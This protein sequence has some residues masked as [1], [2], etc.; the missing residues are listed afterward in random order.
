V[1]LLVHRIVAVCR[2]NH[3][4]LFSCSLYTDISAQLWNRQQHKPTVNCSKLAVSPVSLCEDSKLSSQQIPMAYARRRRLPILNL[5]ALED[6][7]NHIG[8]WPPR[9]EDI[10]VRKTFIDFGSF[11][12]LVGTPP[13]SPLQPLNTA[14]ARLGCTMQGAF[15]SWKVVA[16]SSSS[17]SSTLFTEHTPTISGD[18]SA[19]SSLWL[20]QGA[21]ELPDSIAA[22]T[23]TSSHDEFGSQKAFSHRQAGL[24]PACH[25]SQLPERRRPISL[26]D[27]IGKPDM[28]ESSDAGGSS[29]EEFEG[30][31]PV[32]SEGAP[33]PSLG[34]A[35]HGSG[36]CKRCCF[37]PKGRCSNG[38]DCEFCHFSHDK[39]KNVKSKK[40]KSRRRKNRRSDS[41]ITPQ[42]TKA[43]SMEQIL[44]ISGSV[45]AASLR[46]RPSQLIVHDLEF[47]TSTGTTAVHPNAMPVFPKWQ[48]F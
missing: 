13:E 39:R 17:T 15:D 7:S 2:I 3:L 41:Q 43:P 21:G 32:F 28:Q 25:S 46:H 5:D 8:Q 20:E 37:F 29:D 34:S 42:A 33:L 31:C 30:L 12:R 40:K 35:E 11:A 48:S 19:R 4:P 14:P 27:E 9:S 24:L 45:C 36:K 44:G 16:T 18:S 26:A 22:L 6:W 10:P 38:A 47:V 1:H 23:P